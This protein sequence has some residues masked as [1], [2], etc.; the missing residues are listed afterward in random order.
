M[1]WAELLVCAALIIGAATVLSRYADSRAEKTGLGRA[2]TGGLP[3]AGVTSLPE[4]AAGL[5]AVTWLDAPNLALGS[6]LGS[7][8]FNRLLIARM[9]MA[10]QPGSS[11][12]GR[13]KATRSRRAWASCCWGWWPWRRWWVRS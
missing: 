3:L 5:S 9:D 4:L 8:L 11:W 10:Y 7:C 6:V 2:W 13:R 1:I 12:R